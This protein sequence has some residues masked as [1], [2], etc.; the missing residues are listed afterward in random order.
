MNTSG[1]NNWIVIS[2]QNN[3]VDGGTGANVIW[4]GTGN[5]RFV[6][7]Q[8][9]TDYLYGFSLASH[10][11]LDLSQALAGQHVTTD[12]STLS[13]YIEVTSSGGDALV[14]I[15]TGG[16][17]SFTNGPVAVLRG[18]GA[19]S[20]AGIEQ[21]GGFIPEFVTALGDGPDIKASALFGVCDAPDR[22]P[23]NRRPAGLL[24]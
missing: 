22:R 15:D 13:R 14:S 16:H 4:D 11:R 10:D 3:V 20:L 18:E 2:G 19:L 7:N 5:D 8:G 6:L 9:G 1:G 24:S 23:A 21:L 12:L 17:G